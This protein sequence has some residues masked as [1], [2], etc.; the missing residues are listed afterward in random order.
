MDDIGSRK[1]EQKSKHV[2]SAVECYMKQHGVTEEE[3]FKILEEE[4]S[5]A[6]KDI[7]EDFLKPTAVPVHFLDCV[8]NH[9]RVLNFLYGY[10]LDKYTEGV[11]MKD[12]VATLFVDPIPI[13]KDS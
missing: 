5:N 4:V 9:T 11:L 8:I 12:Y 10:E 6:W 7:N 2:A 3:A 1:F 13:E